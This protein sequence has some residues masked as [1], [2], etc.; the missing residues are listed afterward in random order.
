[1]VMGAGVLRTIS[2][3]GYRVQEA[4]RKGAGKEHGDSPLSKVLPYD[5]VQVSPTVTPMKPW[6]YSV[7]ES[8]RN[9]MNFMDFMY[10]MYSTYFFLS[11]ALYGV[12]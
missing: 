3:T 10:P 5:G 12:L 4:V 1:M 11:L 7:M 9:F 8:E 2:S 6:S